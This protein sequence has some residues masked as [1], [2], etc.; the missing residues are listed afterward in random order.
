MKLDP[1]SHAPPPNDDRPPPAAAVPDEAYY[2]RGE[3]AR[4]WGGILLLIGVVWLVFTLTAHGSFFGLGFVER[5]AA[6]PPQSFTAT[7]VVITGAN[8]NVTLV[9]GTGQRVQVEVIRHGFGWN[10]DKAMHA[11]EQLTV[12]TTE[13]DATLTI[14]LQRP[15]FSWLDRVP[16]AELHL[17]LPAGVSAEA[18]VTSGDLTVATVTGDLR[19]ATVSG[20]LEA[21][22][23]TGSLSA[24]TSSGELTVQRHTG[25]LRAES[26]SGAMRLDGASTNPSVKTV[27]G[28]VHLT[29]A[30][31]T[32][33]LSSISGNLRLTSA[34]PTTLNIESTS[35]D[36]AADV[37]LVERSTSRISNI[38]GD[39]R[40]TLADATNLALDVTTTSGGIQTDLGRESSKERRSFTATRGGGS[41]SLTIST[42]SGD[43]VVRGK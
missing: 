26:V 42:T 40:L 5:S 13:R 17:T 34:A 43:V 10:A 6:L 21:K 41:T 4:R 38:S 9:G 3:Q 35:G 19:L 28:D 31:G 37:A 2:Q 14:E 32:V 30:S 36:I 12:V 24:N 27:S 8:D 33:T 29:G 1:D 39:V 11:L 15:A 20:R 7:R 16:Y 23:T 22:D 18:Q 25:P